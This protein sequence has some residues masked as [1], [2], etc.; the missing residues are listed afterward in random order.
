MGDLDANCIQEK[1]G[2]VENNSCFP[3]S[4][5]RVFRSVSFHIPLRSSDVV[6]VIVDVADGTEVCSLLR[7]FFRVEYLREVFAK[8]D[9]RGRRVEFG[10]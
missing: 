9:E 8:R 5:D 7:G 3:F 2:V 10:S 1:E 6:E 4:E